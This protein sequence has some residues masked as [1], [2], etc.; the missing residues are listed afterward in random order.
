MSRITDLVTRI[1]E[2]FYEQMPPATPEEVAIA[3]RVYANEFGIEMPPGYR[4]LLSVSNGI[5]FNGLSFY[6]CTD[7]TDAEG[8][9][10]AGI[11]ESNQR[12][13]RG[14]H[15]IDTTMRFV[16]E[17]GDDLYGYDKADGKWRNVDRTSWQAGS[18][19][20]VFDTFD[21]L[22]VDVVTFYLDE[23]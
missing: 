17:T 12:L 10:A 2:E 13:I 1:A 23:M 4:E 11:G 21:D 16:G 20:N 8:T 5:D 9:E 22:F 7:T 3:E 14:V 18:A 19:D 6:S 15:E